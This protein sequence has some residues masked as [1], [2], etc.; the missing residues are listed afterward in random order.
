MLPA[1]PIWPAMPWQSMTQEAG[2][3]L[4]ER[5]VSVLPPG[6]TVMIA[7]G[8]VAARQSSEATKMRSMAT[9]RS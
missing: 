6:S 3:P 4:A 1:A 7:A 8:A 5:T 2:S 9:T